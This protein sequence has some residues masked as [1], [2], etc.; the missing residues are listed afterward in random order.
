MEMKQYCACTG[1][2]IFGMQKRKKKLCTDPC[3][4]LET[5][6]TVVLS[7]L[8]DTLD[9]SGAWSP[10]TIIILSTTNAIVLYGMVSHASS[11]AG[12]SNL[13][14]EVSISTGALEIR[15]SKQ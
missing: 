8:H 15:P 6:R 1:L 7:R 4:G 13:Q 5:V 10:G 11:G 14:K 2:I 3:S 9:W 12:E